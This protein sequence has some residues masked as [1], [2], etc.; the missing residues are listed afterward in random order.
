[1]QKII[2]EVLKTIIDNGFEAYIVG[3]YVRD[4]LLGIESND[5]DIC[6][7]ALPKDLYQMFCVSSTNNYGG[8]NLKVREYNFD[9]T[10]FRKDLNYRNRRP[11]EVIYINSLEEDLQ[12]RDFTINSICLNEEEKIIDLING[13]D[14]LNKKLIVMPGNI[15]NKL[16]DDPLRIL[17]A[18]RFAT[19]L[20]F[21]IRKDLYQEIKKNYKLVST[22]SVNRIKQEFTKILLCK[23]FKKGLFLLKEFKI[24]E[25]LEID[26]Q[27]EMIFVNDICGMWAQ[28]QSKN[29]YAFTK[30]ELANIISIRQIIKDGEVNNVTLYNHGLY[31][32]L[33]AGEIL[34]ISPK[35]IEKLYQKLVLKQ[36][37]DLQITSKEIMDILQIKPSKEIAK[38]EQEIIMAILKGN[39]KNKNSEIKKYIEARKEL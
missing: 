6:T 31:N 4:Y 25:L 35:V 30:Q 24:L 5:V 33:V 29:E 2:K 19:V 14:D 9:I 7:N 36:K 8:V 38:L 3:G 39:L 11:T 34:N 28:L 1:M 23:N 12:R 18:I 20:D 15:E 13:V 22:L 37:S 32:C 10:T 27:E 17:R 21:G 16:Q 26:Y